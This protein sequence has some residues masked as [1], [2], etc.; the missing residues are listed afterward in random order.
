[1]YGILFSVLTLRRNWVQIM[2]AKAGQNNIV[3][4]CNPTD[5]SLKPPT[6]KFL[7][8]FSSKPVKKAYWTQSEVFIAPHVILIAQCDMDIFFWKE[9]FPYRPTLKN[10]GKLQETTIFLCPT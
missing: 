6:K 2:Q 9:F 3:V 1:M 7:W 8:P 10:P 5:P 4:S